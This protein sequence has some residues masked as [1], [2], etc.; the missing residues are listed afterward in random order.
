[1]FALTGWIL[2]AAAVLRRN[3]F[4]ALCC[5]SSPELECKHDERTRWT[6]ARRQVVEAPQGSDVC[7]TRN[8]YARAEQRSNGATEQ[9][10]RCRLRPPIIMIIAVPSFD[11]GRPSFCSAE[12]D[13]NNVD[14]THTHTHTDTPVFVRARFAG[15]HG[16]GPSIAQSSSSSLLASWTSPHWSSGLCRFT[17]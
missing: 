17:P 1:M 2:S 14:S 3:L 15:V 5:D 16:Q 4:P 8:T 13:T 11:D 6:S 9:R 7:S 12:E 10:D